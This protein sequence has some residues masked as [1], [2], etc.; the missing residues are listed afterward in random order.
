MKYYLSSISWVKRNN[1]KKTTLWQTYR[2][3]VYLLIIPSL[4]GGQGSGSLKQLLFMLYPHPRNV[5]HWILQ[6]SVQLPFSTLKQGALPKE[7]CL[8]QWTDFLTAVT[9]ARIMPTD[10]STGQL[11]WIMPPWGFSE[12]NLHCINKS[13]LHVCLVLVSSI[14]CF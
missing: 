9:V 13:N 6:A 12:W 8:P 7:W 4:Q 1:N 3:I 11:D 2:E 10:I 5:H 14:A